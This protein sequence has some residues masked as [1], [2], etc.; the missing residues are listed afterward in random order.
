MRK[1]IAA[2][3]WKMNGRARDV[4]DFATALNAI[5][6]S[7]EVIFAP[8]SLY[9]SLLQDKQQRFAASA[10]T[11]CEHGD[12][13]FTGEIS[14]PMLSDINCNYVIVGHSERRALYGESDESIFAKVKAA[15]A[16]NLT[17]I[18]C[19]G[20]TNEQNQAGLTETVL[21]EQL[22]LVIDNLSTDEKQR[23]VIAYEPV[24]A[25]GSGRTPSL[26]DIQNIHE[27][28]RYVFSQNDD[29]ISS[30][31]RILYGGSVKPDNAEAI[32][33]LQDVDGG[34]V[35]GAS[36]TIESFEKIIKAL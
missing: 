30:S 12:G 36:L 15:F 5:E 20:E 6:T 32:F 23:L 2:A 29:T 16:N 9:L 35:G 3:N 10:Q 24:W 21:S 13:A 1:P 33:S 34:L 31:V 11:G 28:I 4:V 19:I 22:S 27:K 26:E 17:P 7:S 14:M 18:I 25:I 8:P